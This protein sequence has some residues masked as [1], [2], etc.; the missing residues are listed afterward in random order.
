MKRLDDKSVERGQ[1]SQVCS[2]C[3][4][5]DGEYSCHAFVFIPDEIW[6]GKNNHKSNFPGDGGIIFEEAVE[7]EIRS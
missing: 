5:Y 4:H 3:K 1:Y 6:F 7:N 2:F